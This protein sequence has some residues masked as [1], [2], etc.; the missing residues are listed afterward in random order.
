MLEKLTSF[1]G[2]YGTRF[3]SVIF[4]L[5]VFVSGVVAELAVGFVFHIPIPEAQMAIMPAAIAGLVSM[6]VIYPFCVS[7]MQLHKHEEHLKETQAELR[8]SERR[9]RDFAEAASDWYWEMDGDLKFIYF[10]PRVEQVTGVPIEFHIGKTREELA[11]ESADNPK[12]QAHF[13][14]LRAR[15]AFKDFRYAR[16]GHDDR[17]QHISTSGKPIYGAYG[18]FIGYRGVGT[19][20]TAQVEAVRLAQDSQDRLAAAIEG[21]S[22]LF[23]LWDPDDR[24]VVCNQRFRDLNEDVVET[25]RPGTHFEDHLRAVVEKGLYPS[26][27]G[28]EEEW[29]AERLERHLNPSGVFEGERQGGRRLL[30]NE[31]LLPDGSRATISTDIS[32]LKKAIGLTG[33]KG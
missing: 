17:I 5:I 4:G 26:A 27:F 30:I 20:I 16:R 14:D 1:I 23:V 29:I 15:R 32:G 25:T 19:D 2:L 8:D 11:S 33:A 31:L 12:W 3:S 9:F 22:E 28:R 7:A 18:E 21:M 6:V 13:A 10:S 24:L